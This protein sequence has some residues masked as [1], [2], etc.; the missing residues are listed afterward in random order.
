[1]NW[2]SPSTII[3]IILEP[4][5]SQGRSGGFPPRSQKKRGSW[6]NSQATR[7]RTDSQRKRAS[8]PLFS[9]VL[10]R[11]YLAQYEREG[12][13]LQPPPGFEATTVPLLLPA[14]PHSS[15]LLQLPFLCRS[16]PGSRK[17]Q[18]TIEQA[19]P[20]E[21]NQ[22]V[23]LLE[24][25]FPELMMDTY[26]NYVCQTLV[27]SCS[28]VQ[29]LKLLQRLAGDIEKVAKDERG[30]HAL[31]AFIA[32]V[33][34]PE[35][36]ELLIAGL[37]VRA[38]ELSVHANAAHVV[39]KLIGTVKDPARLIEV[40]VED[41]VELSRQS[42]G[43]LVV[44][45]AIS[46]TAFESS[47]RLR[48][49]LV[50]QSLFLMQDPYANY[51]ISHMLEIWGAPVCH[52]VV[53]QAQGKL[54]QLALQKFASNV[55][56]KMLIAADEDTREALLQELFQSTS[57]REL[58]TNKFSQFVLKTAVLHASAESKAQ[59]K[60]AVAALPQSLQAQ[61]RTQWDK[62]LSLLDN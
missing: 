23:N 62:V 40:L 6:S 12:V 55:L 7:V 54:T 13:G 11:E 59:L 28:P 37:R 51:A 39:H 2:S 31:Q 4:Q 46:R 27:Q 49:P 43:L 44:K 29:R 33:T 26:G 47:A 10:V 35:E 17:A 15:K 20:D 24:A 14:F 36:E 9:S 19:S 34:Q 38:R 52:E 5:A 41:I 60:A 56:E 58:L 8:A 61:R 21:L 16:K 30:T 32:L 53:A 22:I 18:N 48:Y 3:E 50:L 1:M 45:V 25:D 57:L 42:T